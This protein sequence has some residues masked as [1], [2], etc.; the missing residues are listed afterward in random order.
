MSHRLLCGVLLVVA[1]TTNPTPSQQPGQSDSTPRATQAPL[2]WSQ[3]PAL[4]DPI[5]YGG[6]F[7]G[8]HKQAL[9]VA[10]GANFPEA[11]PWQGGDKVWHP[12][13]W[14][15]SKSD[16][17]WRKGDGLPRPLAY[18]ATVSVPAGMVVIGGL[19]K[20]R[21]Y[22]DVFLL[23][24]NNDQKQL[25]RRTLPDLPRP[26]G[27]H[28]AAAIG[29]KIYVAAGQ[30]TADPCTAHKDFWVLDLAEK[31]GDRH[32]ETLPNWP[33][34]PRIKTGAAAQKRGD[35]TCFYLFGG[36]QPT[37]NTSGEIDRAYPTSGF[38]YD[39]ATRTWTA[40]TDA[41][42][43]VA[44]ACATPLG[45]S[46]VLVFS[47]APG[48]GADLPIADRPPF[49]NT[50]HAYHTITDT[51]VIASNMPT[52]VVTTGVTWWDDRIV[53]ASGEVR[54][55]IR[56]N[57]VQVAEAVRQTP[58]FGLVNYSVLVLYLLALVGMGIYFASRERGTEDF[59]LAGRRI[60]WWAAGLS[61][62]ATQLS[63]ITYIATP[64]LAFSTNWTVAPMSFTILL[65]A[66]VVVKYFLPF[67]RRLNV[68][69]AYQYLEKRFGYSVRAFGSLSFMLFQFGRMAIVVY[70]P[71]LALAAI[72]GIDV[73]ASILIMGI[74]ATAYTVLGGMEAV[75]WTDVIQTLVLFG[76]ML[77]SLILIIADG[78]SFSNLFAEA[79][80]ANKLQLLS[81]SMSFTEIATWSVLMGGFLLNLAPY[82][83]D[84]AVV[85]RYLTT[86][87]EKSAARGIW[88]NGLMAIP[89]VVCFYAL[90]TSMW[91]FFRAHPQS[92]VVGMK[93]DEVFPLF[94]ADHLPVGIS[95]LVIAGVFAASMSSLDSS[96]HSIATAFTEDFYKPL[97]KTTRTARGDL[98]VAR[99]VTLAMGIVG[100]GLAVILASYDIQ[101]LFLFFQKVL[102][103]LGSG[104]VTIFLLGIFTRRS[105]A[106]GVITGALAS[107]GVMFF[108][109][110]YSPVHTFVYP[111]IG[112][113]TG[114]TVGYLASLLIQAP[115][116]DTRGLTYRSL[117]S[118]S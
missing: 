79:E 63:A 81:G 67:F 34:G 32:W 58:D 70:L 2:R 66:P 77:L 45:Q 110:Q 92:L 87:D 59:F 100:T 111:L 55:G 115:P 114:V 13:V 25:K 75:I 99:I 101:S 29:S 98:L 54:P 118:R 56:T 10:G 57:R 39:P 33:G 88:L 19:D 89:G 106:T 4:P 65:M 90:G 60:P 102:G 113:S 64:A 91:L 103:L 47:G 53:I 71:A 50:V 42:M 40:V 97:R 3:L 48:P 15:L 36:E 105:H 8:S 78:D 27:F 38:R 44:A 94:V 80:S 6:P 112:I 26:S 20:V 52:G 107:G 85:Q 31:P 95:G 104:L 30:A 5:G 11:P 86:K 62:Y 51:W 23:Q 72:T 35:S 82:T 28:S 24:W 16:R 49:E 117:E 7:V 74:L 116:R 12:D 108:V 14:I 61:I 96:M 21:C 69:T 83:T 84:Q 109:T 41:P 43:S 9:I 18:G 46:H 17:T 1:A 68:T 93:T 37:R 76:G 22:A 73:Y